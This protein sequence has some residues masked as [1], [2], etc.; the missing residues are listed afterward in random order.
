M[1]E[2]DTNPIESVQSAITFFGQSNEQRKN[3]PTNDKE[4]E[5]EREIERLERELAAVK[6][7]VEAKDAAHKQALVKL[8]HYQK[9]A[10]ELSTLLKNS[11]AKKNFYIKQS[12]EAISRVVELESVLT[13]KEAE[14][15]ELEEQIEEKSAYIESLQLAMEKAKEALMSCEIELNMLKDEAAYTNDVEAE[16]E[17]VKR[18]LEKCREQENEAQVEIAL[19]KFQVH[20][21]R[22]KL[23][24]AEAAEARA[25]S[26]KTALYN[27]LQQMGLEAEE[28]E[29]EKRMLKEAA[30]K[31]AHPHPHPPQE[32]L[33]MITTTTTSNK[34]LEDAKR[35]LE[36]AVCKIGE[37]R[38]RA[39]QATSRAQAAEKAKAALEEQNKKRREYKER[40]KAALAA[41]RL[42]SMAREFV[43]KSIKEE[44]E[45]DDD[46][47]NNNDDDSS[48]IYQ[49]L[50]KVLN[51]K[52]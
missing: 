40:R 48:K 26:E 27:A 41:L 5:R 22:S 1:G 44:D 15:L 38:T 49:P 51:M 21:G 6:V 47:T 9:T 25:Q 46:H 52:F 31:L 7:Q 19:L 35:E 43:T 45:D 8:D 32:E 28:T 14:K 4:V 20:K 39:E 50:G 12:E 16:V 10:D 13:A 18:E 30:A 33:M 24:A 36:V 23:A 29:R 3:S 11:D 34:E 2:I 37:L 42:E 17:S